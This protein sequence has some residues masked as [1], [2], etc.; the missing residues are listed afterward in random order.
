MHAEEA[1]RRRV[2]LKQACRAVERLVLL[3][4]SENGGHEELALEAIRRSRRVERIATEAESRPAMTAA[5][6]TLE[7]ALVLLRAGAQSGVASIESFIAVVVSLDP[8]AT[9]QLPSPFLQMHEDAR[10]LAVE[11]APLLHDADEADPVVQALHAVQREL[12]SVAST[13]AE[14]IGATRGR[15]RTQRAARRTV[16]D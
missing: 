5:Q 9:A 8:E 16:L 15:F 12:L 13:D 1:A 4:L 2:I 6:L 14:G 10:R 7:R 3:L 11:L